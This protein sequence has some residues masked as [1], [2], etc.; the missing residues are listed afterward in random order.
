MIE[1]KHCDGLNESSQCFYWL[2]AGFIR[3]F[4]LSVWQRPWDCR[5]SDWDAQEHLQSFGE[6]HPY[7]PEGVHRSMI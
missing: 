1:S 4:R 3:C 5:N 6:D 2:V 7:G